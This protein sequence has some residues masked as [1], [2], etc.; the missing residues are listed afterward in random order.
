MPTR[1]RV[2]SAA[3]S[4]GSRHGGRDEQRGTEGR[5]RSKVTNREC[6]GDRLKDLVEL[7]IY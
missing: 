2:G 7:L 4:S 3:R 1:K 5:R 6:E